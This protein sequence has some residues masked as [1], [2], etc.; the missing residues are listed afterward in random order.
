MSPARYVRSGGVAVELGGGGGDATDQFPSASLG[1]GVDASTSARATIVCTAHATP[2]TAGDWVEVDPSL[3][4]DAAGVVVTLTAATNASGADTSTLLEIGTGAAASEVVWATVGIGYRTLNAQMVVPGLLAAGTRVAVRCRSVITL[5]T[6]S[7]AYA[8]T[9]AKSVALGAPSTYGADTATSH[10]VTLT[11]PG[12]LNTKSAWTEI[13]ASTAA[14]I[15]ALLVSVQ[16]AAATALSGS[17]VLIDIA[18]GAAGSEVAVITDVYLHGDASERYDPRSL[19][20][21]GLAISAGSRIAARYQRASTNNV[22]DLI[23]VGA[24]PA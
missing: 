22:V 17:G 2:H 11:A 14:D 7:A 13:T 6:V 1:D 16:G 23:L 15:A 8:F 18:V 20:T 12:S 5:K 24:P 10:G 19:L 4:A 21:Y 9:P 3:S